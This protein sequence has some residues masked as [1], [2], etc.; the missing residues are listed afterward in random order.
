MGVAETVTSILGTRPV[1][2]TWSRFRPGLRILAFHDVSDG[3]ALAAQLDLIARRHVFVSGEQVARARTGRRLADNAVW[4]T[5]DDGDATVFRTA[6][7]ILTER[8][9]PA[10]AYVCPGL[11]DPPTPPW[12]E[13]VEAAGQEGRGAEIDGQHLAGTDLVG[14]LKTVSDADRRRAMEDLEPIPQTHSEPASV[15]EL[16]A[17]AAAGFEVGNHTWDHPCLDRCTP[18]EQTEQITRAHDW[19]TERF[20]EAPSTFAYP[21]G[22]RT[23]HALAVLRGLGYETV[24]RFDHRLARPESG[25]LELSRLRIDAGT[26]AG[27]TRAILSGAHSDLLGIRD[28]H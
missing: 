10:T 22:D 8:S 9:I 11:L 18:E 19:L 23:D 7:P 6:Q 27:R 20:G 14:K 5:F 2:A 15:D 3:D 4:V 26:D 25:T 17:W 28:G 1:S 12:W 24:L 16:D 21:N 13:Q